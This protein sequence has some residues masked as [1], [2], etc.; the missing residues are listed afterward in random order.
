MSLG[1]SE[2]TVLVDYAGERKLQ[3]EVKK[4]DFSFR[5]LEKSGNVYVINDMYTDDSN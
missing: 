2:K 3:W 1:V 5:E 4:L